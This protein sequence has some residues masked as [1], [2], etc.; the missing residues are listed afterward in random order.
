M[1]ELTPGTKLSKMGNANLSVM[2]C[3]III[4]KV[5]LSINPITKKNKSIREKVEDAGCPYFEDKQ[6]LMENVCLMP[7]YQPNKP[8]ESIS[9]KIQV[10]LDYYEIPGVLDI[11]E[12]KNKITVDI[13]QH[14]EWKDPRIRANFSAMP[15]MMYSTSHQKLSPAEIEKIWHPNHDMF[16]FNLQDW[17]YLYD[18]YWFQSVGILRCPT[19][20]DCNLNQNV[21]T[22]YANKHWIV[23]LF[24]KFDFSKFPMDTQLCNYRQIFGSTS[25]VVDLFLYNQSSSF[26]TNGMSKEKGIWKYEMGGFDISIKP[27]GTIV[28]PNTTIQSASRDF[29]FNIQ[30]KRIFQ[31]YLYQTYLPCIAI[32]GVSFISFIIPLS[33][34]P[35]RVALM[36]T[37]F[38]TLTNIF[39]QQMVST[40]FIHSIIHQII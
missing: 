25:D 32:V 39:I 14:L 11:D 38:L 15:N 40:G 18:P 7:H 5:T 23:T 2:F 22:L 27:I 20:R 31:P 26:Y 21:T 24:C 29:G 1:F 12:K 10:D 33:A 34:I 36:A 8:S 37:I 6:L 13:M 9:D 16:T 19:M 35:G 17:K 28:S 4:I 30:F 3:F